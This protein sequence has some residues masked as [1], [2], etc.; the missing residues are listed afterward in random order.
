MAC[1][2]MS[3]PKTGTGRLATSRKGSVYILSTL[4]QRNTHLGWYVACSG[5]I[6]SPSIHRNVLYAPTIRLC[7]TGFGLGENL[8]NESCK[9]GLQLGTNVREIIVSL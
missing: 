9:S 8:L 1:S 7:K 4:I 6:R 2:S 5:Y 3:E